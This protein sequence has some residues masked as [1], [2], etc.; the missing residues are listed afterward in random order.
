MSDADRDFGNAPQRLASLVGL[1]ALLSEFGVPLDAFLSGL[2][3]DRLVFTSDEN[4]IPYG[5]A[6]HL[7]RRA[8]ELSGCQHFCLLLGSRYDHRC[9]GAAGRWMQ[10]APTLGAALNGFI[11]LQSTATRGATSYLHRHGG[12]V[13]FGYGAF[14]RSS[15]DHAHNYAVV[16]PMAYN[17][18]NMLSGGRARVLEVLFSFRKPTDT[19]PYSDFFKV[20]VRFDQPESGLLMA[21]SSLDLP[22]KGA[23][24]V[25]FAMLQSEANGLMPPGEKPWSDR[26]TRS[27]RASLPLA[28]FKAADVASDLCIHPKKLSRLLALERSSY[29]D[30]LAEVRYQ[31]ASELLA[32]TDLPVSEIALAMGYQNH[33]AFD[34]AFRLWSGMTPSGWR[35]D[36]HRPG[37][38]PTSSFNS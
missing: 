16:I 24:P 30:L 20:P 31:A 38:K 23:S 3:I 5:L 11:A 4:R 2:P 28:R 18:V 21:A 27:L 14:D 26:V 34:A 19:R 9:M 37:T 6:T 33:A 36:W 15:P 13:I 35:A 25:D 10:N 12:D 17:I 32:T 29:R 1:P 22:V 8:V 7:L